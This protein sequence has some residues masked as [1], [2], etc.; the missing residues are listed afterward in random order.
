MTHPF[1]VKLHYAFQSETR[2]FIVMDLCRGGD[3]GAMLDK[4]KKFPEEIAKIY[5]A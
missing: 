2:L 3:L 4:H 5:V 1:I